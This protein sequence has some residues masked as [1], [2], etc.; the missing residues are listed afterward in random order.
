MLLVLQ[1]QDL[2]LLPE[3][4]VAAQVVLAELAVQQVFP[5]PL[6]R[7]KDRV[8]RYFYCAQRGDELT[9][10]DQCDRVEQDHVHLFRLFLFRVSARPAAGLFSGVFRG[11][12]RLFARPAGCVFPVRRDARADRAFGGAGAQAAAVRAQGR[13]F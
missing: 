4:F 9:D 1:V 13:V 7:K 12:D 11:C 3:L 2:I 6:R 8:H 10:R 5:V